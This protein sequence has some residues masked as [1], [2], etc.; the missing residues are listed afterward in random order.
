MLFQTCMTSIVWKWNTIEVFWLPNDDKGSGLPNEVTVLLIF[1]YLK[2]TILHIDY[3]S[4]VWKHSKK[5]ALKLTQYFDLKF[6]YEYVFHMNTVLVTVSV[7]T[8]EVSRDYY[9]H[10]STAFS[11][12]LVHYLHSCFEK[13]TW[14][15]HEVINWK[16]LRKN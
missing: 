4:N 14:N 7:F 11:F 2:I 5:I 16:N 10:I 12:A 9:S 3:H 1:H 13:K 15:K 6:I 8:K